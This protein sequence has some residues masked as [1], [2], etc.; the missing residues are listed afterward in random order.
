MH[1]AGII[2]GIMLFSRSNEHNAGIMSIFFSI[3]KI[4]MIM[5]MMILKL[6]FS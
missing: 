3:K 5:I 2:L 1:Y 6:I 4:I